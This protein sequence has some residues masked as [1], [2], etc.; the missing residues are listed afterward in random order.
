MAT[1]TTESEKQNAAAASEKPKAAAPNEKLKMGDDGFF[2]TWASK[3]FFTL[4]SVK[5]WG[6]VA[7]TWV[8]TY[9]IL[10]N[11]IDPAAKEGLI[12]GGEWVTF[13]TTVWALIFGMKEIF[14]I[15]DNKDRNEKEVVKDHLE[16]KKQIADINATGGIGLG[17]TAPVEEEYDPTATTVLDDGTEVVGEEPEA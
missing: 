12:D 8:S 11:P 13:N 15:S 3:L 5:V 4:I 14:K 7:C 10:N 2:P 6:L 9:L 1:T 16:T 17:S